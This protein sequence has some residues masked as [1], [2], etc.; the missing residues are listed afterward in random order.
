MSTRRRNQSFLAAC[1]LAAAVLIA[2]LAIPLIAL[3]TSVAP[4]RLPGLLTSPQTLDA[5][6]VTAEAN[7]IA[8]ALILL[9]GTPAAYLI[10]RRSFAGRRAL[11]TLIEL[12]L[13]LPPAVAG[14]ALIVA[15]GPN[16]PFGG[17]LA[18]AGLT[19]PFTEVAVVLAVTFVAA[20]FY[21]RSAISAFAAIDG[22]CL[23]AARTLGAG[24]FR[25][26]RRIALP[27]SAEGLRSG[28][29]LAFARGVGEFG[30]TLVFAGSVAGVTQ[31]L[32]LAVYAE[33][34]VSLDS[35][36]AIGI[37]LLAVSAAILLLSK[38]PLLW[39]DSKSQ[40]ATSSAI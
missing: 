30:A 13:V 19:I 2:F 38:L 22:H 8:D 34:P 23:D 4:G 15:F 6:R 28:W 25:V 33:L 37:L 27:L 26:F 7:L 39:T 29:A 21:L 5:V 18:S 9:F 36:I 3:V 12:P 11:I 40:S 10:A 16:G 31:T 24:R 14:I 35:A 32:P 17:A 20:P 1:V